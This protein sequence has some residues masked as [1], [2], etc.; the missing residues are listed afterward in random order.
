[1]NEKMAQA[2][3]I[4][5]LR[6]QALMQQ[7]SDSALNRQLR[8]QMGEQGLKERQAKQDELSATQAKQ[9][10]LAEMGQKAEQQYQS[11]IQ[12]GKAKGEFDPTSYGDIID[13]TSWM[14]NFLK[15]GSAKE[16][17]AAKSAWVESYLRDA[18]GAAIAPSER[19]AYAKD[20]FPEPGDTQE[21]IQNKADLR[22]QKMQTALMGAGPMGKQQMQGAPSAQPPETKT[23]QGKTYQ[24]M[25]GDRKNPTSWKVIGE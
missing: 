16:A 3:E 24:F 21:I 6:R 8:Q 1:M 12:R 14:P 10:G 2:Q 17:E 25:G 4:L 19:L 9:L 15:S 20:F 5:E 23:Y 18:S 22:K 7:A 11:A 13:A